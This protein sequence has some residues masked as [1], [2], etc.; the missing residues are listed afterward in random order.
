MRDGN[1]VLGSD[2]THKDRKVAF[3]GTNLPT[4]YGLELGDASWLCGSE[5]LLE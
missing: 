5:G 3:G 2:P 1:L 4:P